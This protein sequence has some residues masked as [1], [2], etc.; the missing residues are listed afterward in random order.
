[1][2]VKQR[3]IKQV[4]V[5]NRFTLGLLNKFITI[6]KQMNCKNDDF[7]NSNLHKVLEIRSQLMSKDISIKELEDIFKK[8]SERDVDPAVKRKSPRKKAVVWE[9]YRSQELIRWLLGNTRE[10]SMRSLKS[11]WMNWKRKTIWKLLQGNIWT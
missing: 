3:V 5:K 2:E 4:L 1:M 9:T 6:A 8:D 10:S 11:L 7:Y